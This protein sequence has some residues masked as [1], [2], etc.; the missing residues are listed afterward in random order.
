MFLIL[1]LVFLRPKLVFLRQNLVFLRPD[2][3]S[4][5]HRDTRFGLRDADFGSS[6]G[7]RLWGGSKSVFLIPNLMFLRPNLVFLRAK[8]V[9][10]ILNLVFLTQ[11][12]VFL[13][14]PETLEL[15]SETL[16]LVPAQGLGSGVDQNQCFCDKI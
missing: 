3:V 4:G 14:H 6:S 1:N 15:A 5:T 2:R 11:I 10:L 8:L 13:G 7:F 9:L 12:R 16:I